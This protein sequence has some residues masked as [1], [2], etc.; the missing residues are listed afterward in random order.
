M[1]EE[2]NLFKEMIGAL[3]DLESQL[4]S[5]IGEKKPT[6]VKE[7]F[8]PADLNLNTEEDLNKI[9]FPLTQCDNETEEYTSFEDR[10]NKFLLQFIE[11]LLEDFPDDKKDLVRQEAI[12]AMHKTTF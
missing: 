6:D 1:E 7:A 9:L 11:K 10:E 5:I 2:T 12:K 3:D 4:N 8:P